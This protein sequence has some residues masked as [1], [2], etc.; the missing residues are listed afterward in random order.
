MVPAQRLR[1]KSAG[2]LYGLLLLQL[3]DHLA[4]RSCGGGPV[5]GSQVELAARGRTFSI[6]NN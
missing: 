4:A 3:T 2:M 5:F 1:R 6:T